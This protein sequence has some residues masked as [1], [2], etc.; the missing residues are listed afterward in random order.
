MIFW[1]KRRGEHDLPRFPETVIP[2]FKMLCEAI[3]V[4]EVPDLLDAVDQNFREMQKAKQ[5]NER[6][7]VQGAKQLAERCHFLLERYEAFTEEEQALVIG[8]VRYFAIAEDPYDD[9]LF[10]TGLFDD[11]KVMNYVLH[12]LGLDDHLLHL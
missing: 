11:K 2:T 6:I 1:F 9:E 8:A 5:E 10:A 4:D 7:D 3:P 12:R